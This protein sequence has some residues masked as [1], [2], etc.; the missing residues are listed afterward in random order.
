MWHWLL[1]RYEACICYH[2][3]IE[4]V[5]SGVLEPLAM[6]SPKIKALCSRGSDE[7]FK[8][9][10]PEKLNDAKWFTRSALMRFV[11]IVSS[12]EVLDKVKAM[13]NEI[14]QLEES[15]KFHASIYAKADD[16]YVAPDASKNELLR[17][18]ELRRTT[19]RGDLESAWYQ[20]AGSSEEIS[21]ILKF[22]HHFGAVDLSNSLQKFL[23]LSQEDMPANV[24]EVKDSVPETC[25]TQSE[26]PVI[27]GASP[28]KAAQIERQS[29]SE[30]EESSCI[31]EEDQPSVER[32]RPLTRSASPR[33]SASPMRRIQIGRSGTRR[34][35][36][37]T[38]KSLSYFPAREKLVCQ[39]K[40]DEE[41]SEQTSRTSENNVRRMSVQDRISLFEGK[42]KTQT[43]DTQKMKSVLNAA[44]VMAANKAVLRRWS[45]GMGDSSSP[46][47]DNP[48]SM[49]S[50][51][52][53]PSASE[54]I[55]GPDSCT[56]GLPPEAAEIGEK[57][58][59]CEERVPS[60][61]GMEEDDLPVQREEGSEMEAASAER[62]CQKDEE[63]SPPQIAMTNAQPAE[64]EGLNEQTVRPSNH[65]YRE[66]RNEKLQGET[67]RK[68]VERK[69]P[70]SNLDEGIARK[71]S[72]NS[73]TVKKT[74]RTLKNSLQSANPKDE[75]SKPGVVKKAS[76]AK[77]SPLPATRKSWPS[78]PSP[79][80][81]GA[82]QVKTPSPRAITGV[83][84]ATRRSKPTPSVPQKFERSQQ[85]ETTSVKASPSD[86]RKSVKNSIRKQQ[87]EVIGAS[88]LTKTKVKANEVSK[89][90]SMAPLELKEPAKKPRPFLHKES[91][92]GPGIS[93]GAKS[94]IS[95]P[96]DPL[97][98][99]VDSGRAKENE[100]ASVVY[101]Q[102]HQ[103]E[104]RGLTEVKVHAD[105][106][107]ETQLNI[108]QKYEEAGSS[109]PVTSN[110][111][112][113][114]QSKHMSAVKDD[115]E[116][117]PNISPGAWTKI[118]EHEDEQI[119][120]NTTAT[121]SKP[122]ATE[123]ESAAIPQVH[124]SFSQ[125]FQDESSDSGDVAWGNA[126]NPP[127]MVYQKDAPKGLKKLLKFARK[128]KTDANT[129]RL[130]SQSVISKRGDVIEE[131]I[132]LSK[133]DG[134]NL[135]KKATSHTKNYGNKI[136]LSSESRTKDPTTHGVSAQAGKGKL[137]SQSKS[138]KLP[139][140][141]KAT[142][143]F[144]S[145]SAFKGTKQNDPLVH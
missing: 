129:T 115:S 58:D 63:V 91:R 13:E 110:N 39:E 96:V 37:L 22:C 139:E 97:R 60:H 103:N 98:D 70:R 109:N 21:D 5:A 33:R 101:E 41:E 2:N 30:G 138:Q 142:R 6:Q 57:P 126:D 125:P 18:M 23:G 128:S 1:H 32:S 76:S 53:I 123:P 71:T 28:A 46:A 15:L 66:K 107:T 16:T 34:S 9:Q 112:V 118:E 141:A 113:D 94:K 50:G 77:A 104:D 80:A 122:L 27:Y 56:S 72:G 132:A 106:E 75:T 81:I 108:P 100:M 7:T 48:H 137:V 114:F 134:D 119:P 8:L 10:P 143:S 74:Q 24:A 144:F 68:R 130:S 61:E 25:P 111:E 117:E 116:D 51:Q 36:A 14:S 55:L 67:D 52:E 99:S 92:T 40:S 20:A 133:K 4:T 127:T 83:I 120:S 29:S 31:S 79:R 140:G 69:N 42:Q 43:D 90:S 73:S 145:L 131:T 102:V 65:R 93:P 95:P 12:S 47:S 105:L 136:A 89:K 85:P 38:I 44:P 86:T 35:T 59:V 49:E 87:Q 45:A 62:T 88:K 19:L 78:T 54:A 3:K 64:S 121:H 26:T 17:A 11:H 124:P 84:P 82:S 135:L